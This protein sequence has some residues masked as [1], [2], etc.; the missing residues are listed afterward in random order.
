MLTRLDEIKNKTGDQ[1][2]ARRILSELTYLY[3]FAGED[4]ALDASL[5][6]LETAVRESGAITRETALAEE[7]ALAAYG[8]QA[9]S[10]TL[11]CAA[12]AHIDMNWM[13]S[14]PETVNVVIDT[15]QTMLTLMDEYPAF[16][17]SQSQASTYEIVEKYAP[18]ML[19]AI[20]RRVQE[21]RWEVA[22]THWVEPDKNMISAESMARHLL[23]TKQYLS[24]LLEIDPA[25][26]QLDFEPD[27]FGHPRGVPEVLSHAGVKYM[28]H[29]RGNEDEEIYRWR[30]PSGAETLVYREPNWYNNK[31]DY[32]MCA[33]LPAFCRRNHVNAAL[34]VYGVGD[35]GGGPTR[36]DLEQMLEMR[37][38]PLMPEIRCGR[39]DEYFHAIEAN[40]ADFPVVERELNF[41][42]TGCYTSQSR[43]KRA[44]RL[45]EDHLYDA[46][47]LGSM[48][49]LAGREPRPGADFSKAWKNVLF[50]QFHD[51]LPGS[52]V[53]D[54]REYALGLF[55]ETDSIATGGMNRAMQ[56][57]A[58]AVDTAALGTP[59]ET[60]TGTAMGAGA[61]HGAVCG[62]KME[63]GGFTPY[64]NVSDISRGGGDIRAFVLFNTTQYARKE[65]VRLTLWDWDLPLDQTAVYSVAAEELPFDILESGQR[66][67][68]HQYNTLAFPA[69]VPA[70]GYAT[71]YVARA[72]T[73]RPA[74]YKENTRVQHLD[75]RNPVLENETLR[76]EFD[77]RTLTLISWKDK[78]SGRELLS[79]P[80]GFR[81]IEEE[82]VGFFTAWEIGRY[83][84]VT[85]LQEDQFVHLN[86]V[87]ADQTFG[88]L[89]YTLDFGRST[90]SVHVTL[91]GDTLR[92]STEL[93]WREESADGK[94]VPQLQYTVPYAY[95]AD[96]IR[97]DAAAG[98]AD[99]QEAD[100]D[101]PALQYAAP[102]CEGGGLMLTT[103]SKY[104]YRAAE[105]ALSVS[106][107]R[108]SH[109]PDKLPEVGV[110]TMEIG[111]CAVPDFAPG[112]LERSAF[113]FAHPLYVRSAPVRK[114][115]L[116]HTESLLTLTGHT[117]VTALKP[118]EDG[119]GLVLRMYQNGKSAQT[120]VLTNTESAELTDILENMLE[121]LPV[122]NGEVTL[123]LPPHT[124]CSVRFT[125][126]ARE[127]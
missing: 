67:W 28:Y 118:A 112:T 25:G 1:P 57:I 123:T 60:D 100:H 26:L 109:S 84:K 122:R 38:C 107:I 124:L 71:V 82:N 3:N 24:H 116:P 54:T 7:Q 62:A 30:A 16:T 42:Y 48:A 21:G 95:R 94:P 77:R 69:E 83:G 68:S 53:R 63:H 6:R 86:G 120:A 79:A 11:I 99:R 75:K 46:E 33:F 49:R 35:H 20:R 127:E 17:F 125:P 19:P 111:L 8:K 4:P 76:A 105:G 13:W 59:A 9:K 96:C 88:R 55:Q 50:N 104:G 45:G 66:Y 81:L 43:I 126:L 93:N 73:I 78:R 113:C 58:E 39:I 65:R 102:V 22:A 64:C 101:V 98:P 40:I 31:I 34:K 103:D 108:S 14:M 91:C 119:E 12:H 15:F 85:D 27:T 56:A 29:C 61:G 97:C 117:R 51:I 5:R 90:L 37:G 10:L 89:S 115:P 80:A 87:H 23:Y 121:P 110:H 47:A 18:S 114:G 74:P 72:K 52:G 41:I 44:N 70:F 36:R 2:F 106:L 92:L 32:G